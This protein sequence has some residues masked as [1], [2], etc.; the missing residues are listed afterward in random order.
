VISQNLVED[1]TRLDYMVCSNLDIYGLALHTTEWLMDHDLRMF[2]S[3][4][5]PLSTASKDNRTH[6]CSESDTDSDNIWLDIL[7]SIIYSKTSGHM[8]SR[9]VHIESDRSLRIYFLE[10]EELSYN[11]IGNCSIDSITEEYNTILEET[12]V[13]IIRAFL[14]TYL[15]D[16]RWDEK[17]GYWLRFFL[18][19]ELLL[20]HNENK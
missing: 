8:S 13:Y 16:D 5:F 11:C 4:A 9:R 18:R 1:F 14:A 7:H 19:L 10:I 3:I 17:V 15:V 6:R 2:E 12:R 20:G